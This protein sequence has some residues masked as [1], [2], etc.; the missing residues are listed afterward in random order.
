MRYCNPA[1]FALA[2]LQERTRLG[3]CQP[4]KAGEQR[5]WVAVSQIAEKICLH[6]AFGEKLLVAAEAGLAGGKE[7]FVDLGVVE[8]GHWSAVEPARPCGEHHVRPLQAGIPLR[9]RL[10]HRGIALE[11]L[12]HARVLRKELGQPLVELQIVGDDD[13]DRETGCRAP[14]RRSVEPCCLPHV[15]GRVA[16]LCKKRRRAREMRLWRRR[17]DFRCETAPPAFPR[18]SPLPRQGS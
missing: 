8:A 6:V 3:E 11:Q 5:G 2:R 7:L 14:N 1:S 9:C 12:R 16:R 10:H 4:G 13:G 18:L 17:P 15:I